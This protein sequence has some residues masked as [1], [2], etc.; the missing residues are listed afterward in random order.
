MPPDTRA[1]CRALRIAYAYGMLIGAYDVMLWP[2]WDSRS[3][4]KPAA[5]PAFRR[6]P[7]PDDEG[8]QLRHSFG[9]ISHAFFRPIHDSSIRHPHARRVMCSKWCPCPIGC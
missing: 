8:P 1:V 7:Q 6:A 4:R 9:T 2:I 5:E 3:P